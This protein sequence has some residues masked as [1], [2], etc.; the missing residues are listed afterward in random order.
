MPATFLKGCL[1]KEY[2]TEIY[3]ACLLSI[4]YLLSDPLQK[5][6]ANLNIDD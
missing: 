6:F 1:K 3:V 2:V 4:K 5:K